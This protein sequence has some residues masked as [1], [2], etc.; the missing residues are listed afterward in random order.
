MPGE[1]HHKYRE[2]FASV[3]RGAQVGDVE[4]DHEVQLWQGPCQELQQKDV[5]TNHEGHAVWAR[6]AQAHVRTLVVCL[7]PDHHC[8]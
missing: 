2:A 4:D 7:V 6:L 8:Y 5:R 3:V 1:G